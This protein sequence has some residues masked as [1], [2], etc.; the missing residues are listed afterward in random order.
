MHD[1]TDFSYYKESSDHD[2][3][4]NHTFVE[5]G[6]LK[7]WCKKCNC[8]GKYNR[9]KQ[10]FVPVGEEEDPHRKPERVP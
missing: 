4:R 9:L 2:W 8:D 6:S 3:C 10:C 7:S 1:F 5:T